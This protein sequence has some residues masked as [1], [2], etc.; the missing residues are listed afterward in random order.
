MAKYVVA[1]RQRSENNGAERMLRLK[2]FGIARKPSGVGELVGQGM[3]R[4]WGGRARVR[5]EGGGRGSGVDSFR[6]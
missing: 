1:P 5:W 4:G 2:V 6:F 3:Q